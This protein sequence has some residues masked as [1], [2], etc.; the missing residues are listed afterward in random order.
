[1]KKY[2]AHDI[3]YVIGLIFVAVVIVSTQCGFK[4]QPVQ[5]VEE[6]YVVQPGDTIDGIASEYIRK[7]TGTRRDFLEFRE[8]II[9]HNY[10]LL[11]DRES[12]VMIYPG[13]RLKITYW[14]AVDAK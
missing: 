4:E 7:N 13:D 3:V 8:G 11:K 10:D 1:M 5:F 6:T 2:I 14:K 9:E 12:H